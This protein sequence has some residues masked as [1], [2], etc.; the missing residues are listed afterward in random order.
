MASHT[1]AITELITILHKHIQHDDQLL[2]TLGAIR[3]REGQ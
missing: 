2:E 1:T 3:H